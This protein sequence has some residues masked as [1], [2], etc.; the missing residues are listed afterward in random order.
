MNRTAITVS[1]VPE[2]KGG[3]FIL[4][5]DLPTS[6]AKA[7][8]LGYDAIELFAPSADVVR[9]APDVLRRHGLALATVGSGAGWVRHKLTVT[10]PDPEVRARAR[11]FVVEL[12]D[13]AAPAPVILGSM[14]GR[15][16]RAR[17]LDALREFD[18]E[19]GR[20]GAT[21]LLEPLNRYEGS[22][23]NT[24]AQGVELAR[25][26][27]HTKLLADCFHMAIEEESLAGALAAAAKDV[28]H[29]QLADS[30]RRP[31]GHGHTDW[32]SIAAALR[33][34]GYAGYLSA[35]ALPW[36]DPDTAARLAMDGIRKYFG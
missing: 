25:E 2:A 18:A 7:K 22:L 16:S 14:Q 23:V 33:Q 34:I 35:E 32:P 13:A 20:R 10:D 26:L 6:C 30:N 15:G 4:W 9:A 31:A 3:P 28:G 24:L 1:L 29:I 5:D 27:P 21:F 8:A 19:A 11:R 12:I 36:P 17:L